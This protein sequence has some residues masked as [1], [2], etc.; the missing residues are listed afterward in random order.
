MRRG[1]DRA[2]ASVKLPALYQGVLVLIRQK[3]AFLNSKGNFGDSDFVRFRRPSAS[4]GRFFSLMAAGGSAPTTQKKT[5]TKM[6]DMNGELPAE[7]QEQLDDLWQTAGWVDVSLFF[8][9]GAL[10]RL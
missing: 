5:T 7:I 10:G 2:R 6:T 4:I 3:F 1:V 8:T 9:A